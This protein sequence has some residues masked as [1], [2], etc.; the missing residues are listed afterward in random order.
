M[1]DP[2]FLIKVAIEVGIG[3]CTKM[4]AEYAK[5][6]GTFSQELDFVAANVMMAL[7]ADFMLVWLPAPTLS[8]AASSSVVS[9]SRKAAQEKATRHRLISALPTQGSTAL[10]ALQAMIGLGAS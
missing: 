8:L 1:A 2:S 3:I 5:R 6:Q 10:K 4:S 7:I 9:T